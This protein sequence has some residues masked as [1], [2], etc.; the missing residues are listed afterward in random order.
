MVALD[1][2]PE[3]PRKQSESYFFFDWVLKDTHDHMWLLPLT[4][5][6]SRRPVWFIISGCQ[7]AK[8]PVKNPSQFLV[9]FEGSRHSL[10][11]DCMA[12][13][14]ASAVTWPP[15]VTV[16]LLF[17]LLWGYPCLELGFTVMGC[18]HLKIFTLITS[19]ST[20]ISSR[21]TCEKWK[22]W[23]LSH[24]WLFATPWTVACQTPLST[25][26]S[27]QE[28]WSEK[29]FPSPGDLPDPGIE[30]RTCL[31]EANAML[32]IFLYREN[33]PELR[34]WDPCFCRCPAY[35]RVQPRAS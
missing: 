29:P 22:C 23:P 18:S 21:W 16:C 34:A 1:S 10:A 33:G 7:R 24:A 5:G 3:C 8:L 20:L 35:L 30:R 2:R 4:T 28:Y 6:E 9:G 11:Q 25:E 12:P 19:A 13:I 17:Y 32:T 15:W 14:F 27:G 26:F 31:Q